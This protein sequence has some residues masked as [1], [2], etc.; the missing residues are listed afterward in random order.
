MRAG[1]S[2]AG[3]AGPALGG[4]GCLGAFSFFLP[5]ACDDCCAV[6]SSAG[7]ADVVL[8]SRFLE[9][10]WL[11]GSFTSGGIALSVAVVVLEASMAAVVVGL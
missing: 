3:G 9:I 5:D 7:A 4:F 1:E 6:A 2:G 10:S 11:R 8:D